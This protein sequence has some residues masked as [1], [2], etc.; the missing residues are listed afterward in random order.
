MINT[1]FFGINLILIYIAWTYVLKRSILDNTR[2]K[3]FDLR[4]EI[5]TYY[6]DNQISLTDT[7]YKSLR[8]SINSHLRFTEKKSLVKLV[9]F[10]YEVQKSPQLHDHINNEINKHFSTNN[11][12]LDRFIKKSREKSSIILFQYMVFSSP[13]MM[14]LFLFFTIFIII[15]S[16]SIDIFNSRFIKD[17]AHDVEGYSITHFGY[18]H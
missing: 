12:E 6:I 14:I 13:S 9:K 8:D 5:R 7:T 4:D 11:A 10:I 3:L 18:S 2:D 1:L 15:K 16:I 17:K